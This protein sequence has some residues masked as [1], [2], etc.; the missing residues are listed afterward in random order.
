MDS[1]LEIFDK[2]DFLLYTSNLLKLELN[3]GLKILIEKI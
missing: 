1:S 2:E 3:K